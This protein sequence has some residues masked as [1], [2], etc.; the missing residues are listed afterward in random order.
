MASVFQNVFSS[1][2]IQYLLQLPEVL[3]AKE[4]LTSRVY[5]TIPVTDTIRNALL[6]IGIDIKVSNIPMR[7][8]KG[9]TAPH[10]DTGAK[11]FEKTYLAYINDSAGEFVIDDVSY[12][13]N[14]NTAFVFNEGLL[15]KT[16]NTGYEPR[17]LLGPMNEFAEPV[18]VTVYYYPTEAD[19]LAFTNSYAG[20]TD[21]VVGGGGPYGPGSGYTS[22]RLASNSTGSSS[23][24]VI[25]NNGDLLIND[26]SYNLYPSAPCF[27]EGTKILCLVDGVETYIPI[28]NIKVNTLVKTSRDGFKKVEIIGKGEIQNLGNDERVENRLY[29]CSPKN[30]PELKEDLYLTGCHSVLVDSL[31][32]LQRKETIKHLGKVFVTDRKHRLM[33]CIDTRAEPWAAEG[34]FTIWNLALENT[35]PKMNYGIYANGLLVESACINTL[36]NKSNM[37]V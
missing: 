8:I 13:I 30:Y 17:L 1:E 27:L 19:A 2:Y 9:D 11:T 3:A 28:E 32:D 34:S 31:T 20:G 4:K 35:D 21:F 6:A 15:H 16:V 29:K 22:W 23:K 24:A 37:M 5:F 18:G 33:A 12:P 10:I 7:W 36:K 26:G 25:Y 14:E